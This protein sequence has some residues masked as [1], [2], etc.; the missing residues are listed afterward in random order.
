MPWGDGPNGGFS[1]A[2][3]WLRMA[4]DAATRNVAAQDPDPASVLALYRRMLWLRRRHPALQVGSVPP[5]PV[6]LA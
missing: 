3:P 2:R 4:P 1:K 5:D 6:R